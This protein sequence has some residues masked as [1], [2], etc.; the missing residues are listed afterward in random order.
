MSDSIDVQ[1]LALGLYPEAE[2]GHVQEV[3][4]SFEA[5]KYLNTIILS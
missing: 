2:I 3:L 5:S 1:C 4:P